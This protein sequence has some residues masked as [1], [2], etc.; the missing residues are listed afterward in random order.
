MIDVRSRHHLEPFHDN[1]PTFVLRQWLNIIFLIGAI[2]GI[3]V[4]HVYSREL[5]IYVFIG[6]AVLKFIELSLRMLKL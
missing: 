2:A 4:F 6:A 5:G 3:V 1:G